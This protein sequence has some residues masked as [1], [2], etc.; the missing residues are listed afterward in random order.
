VE[1]GENI[2][3]ARTAVF[4]DWQ[5]VDSAGNGLVNNAMKKETTT[6]LG[7]IPRADARRVQ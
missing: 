4:G 1:A 2:L 3:V 5:R 6:E 7:M